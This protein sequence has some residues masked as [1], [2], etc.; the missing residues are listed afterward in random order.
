MKYFLTVLTVFMFYVGT[1]QQQ[2]FYFTGKALPVVLDSLEKTFHVK[3]SYVNATIDRIT[4]NIDISTDRI[5]PVLEQISAQSAVIFHPVSNHIYYLSIRQNIALDSIMIH[6]FLVK[7]IGLKNNGAFKMNLKAL[8]LIPGN[9]DT[10]I[11]LGIQQLPGVYS[12][13]GTAVNLNVHGGKSDYNKIIWNGIPVYHRG[14]LFGMISPFN[15]NTSQNVTY[16]YKGIPL[17]FND[18]S[19]SVMTVNTT[20]KVAKKIEVNG[21]INGLDADLVANIPIVKQKLG[22]IIS[23]RH[24][25]EPVLKSYT[26]EKYQEKAF[27]GLQID[28]E[29]YSYSDWDIT[30]NFHPNKNNL[31]KINYLSIRNKFENKIKIGNEA[32]KYISISNNDGFNIKWKN[33]CK[34]HKNFQ[35]SYANYTLFYHHNTEDPTTYF[36]TF[37][38][39]LNDITT[40]DLKANFDM[41]WQKH[42]FNFGLQTEYKK[43]VLDFK[44]YKDIFYHLENQNTQTWTHHIYATDTYHFSKFLLKAGG[45]GSYYANIRQLYFDPLLAVEYQWNQSLNLQLHYDQQRQDIFQISETFN[46]NNYFYKGRLWRLADGRQFKPILRQ[47]ITQSIIFKQNKWLFNADIYYSYYKNLSSLYLGHLFN[48][49]N[50]FQNGKAKN[51]GFDLFIKK[52]LNHF[53][54]WVKYAFL[55]SKEKFDRI[56]MGYYFTSSQQV[57]HLVNTSIIYN[58]NHFQAGL[59]WLYRSGTPYTKII[60]GYLDETHINEARLPAFHQLNFSVAYETQLIASKNVRL[61]AAVS[62]RN[63][64]DNHTPIGVSING[65]NT[66]YDE[67]SQ[68]FIYP[69]PLTPNFMLRL[70]F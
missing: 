52:R 57:E 18:F 67:L 22:L 45:K 63:I 1:S 11:F 24:S 20:D 62:I 16:Y 34:I 46:S 55:H 19:S 14:H 70:Y 49:D 6:S 50:R 59:S 43:L 65:K 21:G 37:I 5:D 38:D 44:E 10:D 30:G 35:M 53:N 29:N 32:H 68:D 39:K 54:I 41:K 15:P 40:Y 12:F 66:L 4:V 8:G 28:K 69:L 17:K 61:K 3:F 27:Y 13:D 47:Q 9:I 33:K 58:Y 36:T 25:Y 64:Y 23:T 31:L 42:Q 2:H 51:I 7:G 56:N 26:F 60:D 48:Q